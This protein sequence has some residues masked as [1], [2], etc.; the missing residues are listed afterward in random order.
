MLKFPKKKGHKTPK[1]TIFFFKISANTKISVPTKIAN[2]AWNLGFSSE[3]RKNR[4]KQSWR[5]DQLGEEEEGLVGFSFGRFQI[6][7]LSF[8]PS[9]HAVLTYTGYN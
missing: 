1:F 5:Q 3:E 8:S 4:E 2:T 6:R 7:C 9:L